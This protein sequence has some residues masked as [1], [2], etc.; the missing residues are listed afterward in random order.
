MAL[1]KRPALGA[2]FNDLPAKNK[3]NRLL[4]AAW[5]QWESSFLFPPT[6]QPS[7]QRIKEKV[8]EGI[9]RAE[10]RLP[11]GARHFTG[12]LWMEPEHLGIGA[13]CYFH[14]LNT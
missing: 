12:P 9:M 14:P 2:L 7:R 11:F 10:E 1:G 8:R 5:M 6:V 13:S 4:A 3:A